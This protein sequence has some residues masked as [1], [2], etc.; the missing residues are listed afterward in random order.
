MHHGLVNKRKAPYND[1]INDSDG[2]G[3]DH[4]TENTVYVS[5]VQPMGVKIEGNDQAQMG[6]QTFKAMKYSHQ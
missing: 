6:D 1:R 2:T 3:V 4:Y 5:R